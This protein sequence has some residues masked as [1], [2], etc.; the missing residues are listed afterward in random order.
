VVKEK[1]EIRK[2]PNAIQRYFGETIGELRK[3]SWPTRKEAMNLTIIV[4]IVMVG[5]SFVLGFL[6]Y[7]YTSV[8]SLL[9]T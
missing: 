4:L 3:V 1:K 8:F 5:M 2:K 7:I 9:L 6:D